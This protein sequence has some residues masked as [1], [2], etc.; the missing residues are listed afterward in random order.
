MADKARLSDAYIEA[1]ELPKTGRVELR[2]AHLAGLILRITP[3]GAATWSVRASL[4]DGRQTRASLGTC[5]TMSM[6]DERKLGL[7]MLANIQSGADPFGE[8]RHARNARY[9]KLAG[10]TT[11]EQ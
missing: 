11:V 8:K 9:L 7:K 2:D 6:R 1:I 3:A 10:T 4:K 5:P